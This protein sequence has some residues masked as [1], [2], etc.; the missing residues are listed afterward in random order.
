[1]KEVT[2][3]IKKEQTKLEPIPSRIRNAVY[4][5]YPQQ[6]KR[7]W[8]LLKVVRTEECQMMFMEGCYVQKEGVLAK[9][10]LISLLF[11]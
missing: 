8:R 2:V 4:T 5:S 10:P 7:L 6:V 1:M 11:H 3:V 9:L